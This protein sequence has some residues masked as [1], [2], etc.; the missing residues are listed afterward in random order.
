MT[1]PLQPRVESD[2]TRADREVVLWFTN[3]IGRAF[4]TLERHRV[5]PRG[6]CRG[7]ATQTSSTVW[8]CRLC[9]L[10]LIACDLVA[11]RSPETPATLALKAQRDA[12]D[13]PFR[14][15]IHANAIETTTPMRAV[16]GPPKTAPGI[17]GR[18]GSSTGKR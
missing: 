2:E 12:L 17:S 13:A 5:G 14:A 16:T 7:C 18:P 9:R 11:K 4:R 6:K 3:E 1:I 15:A 8:P 10:A